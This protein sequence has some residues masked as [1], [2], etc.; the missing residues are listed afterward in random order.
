MVTFAPKPP[1]H[2]LLTVYETWQPAAAWAVVVDARVNPAAAST[3]ALPP[4]SHER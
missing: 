2:W 4:A 3:A 1:C